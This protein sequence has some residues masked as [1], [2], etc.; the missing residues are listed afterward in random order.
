MAMEEDVVIGDEETFSPVPEQ[1]QLDFEEYGGGFDHDYADGAG[2]PGGAD[3][4]DVGNG[5][6]FD[7]DAF[8]GGTGKFAMESSQGERVQKKKQQGENGKKAEKSVKAKGKERERSRSL[9]PPPA[10]EK[11]KGKEKAR[12]KEKQ[13]SK[14]PAPPPSSASRPSTTAATAGPY[15]SSARPAASSASARPAATAASTSAPIASGSGSRAKR[16]LP[17]DYPSSSDDGGSSSSDDDSPASG[18]KK[19]TSSS[20]SYEDELEV[21]PVKKKKKKNLPPT[22]PRRSQPYQ[23]NRRAGLSAPWTEAESA[24]LTLALKK[25]GCSD[26][27][28]WARIVALYGKEGKVSEELERRNNTDLASKAKNMRL[29]F[30]RR[31]EEVP[32]WLVSSASSFFFPFPSPFR[33]SPAM[34]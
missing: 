23:D 1:Q 20:S 9:T 22:P 5:V 34:Y 32:G 13:R 21:V 17:D 33:L 24:C 18:Q 31:G 3:E 15:A 4:A 6:A 26:A 12:E 8:V 27:Q 28:C 11:G 2:A 16:P 10:K 25:Y 29:E 30:R 7:F 19:A 14:K